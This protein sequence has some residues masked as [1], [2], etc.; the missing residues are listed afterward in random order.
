MGSLYNRVAGQSLDR[1]GALGDGIFAVAMTLLILDIRVPLPDQIHSEADLWHALVALGPRFV[2][3]V[4]SFVTLGMFWNGHQTQL[5]FLARSDRDLAWIHI[6]FLAF[7]TLIPFTTTLLAQ[8][9][10]Y[11]LALLAYWA[12]I[13]AIGIAIYWSW[14]HANTAGLVRDDVAPEAWSSM[15]RRILIAQSL[16]ALGAALCVFNTYWSIGFI[17]AVQLNYAIAPRWKFLSW[18]G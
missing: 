18:T 14:I 17:F 1:L 9:I 8:F 11:R 5:H 2:M 15:R 4:M 12:N 7:I 16:Y 10:G 3:Y 6:V 13:L